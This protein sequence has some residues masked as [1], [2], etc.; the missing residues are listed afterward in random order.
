MT[1]LEKLKNRDF[2][3]VLDK[4][5]SMEESDTPTGQSRW[6]YA[7]ESAVAIARKICEFDPD[8]ITFIPFAGSFKVY[9]NTTEAALK[10]VFAEHSPMGGTVL[11]PVLK[12][13]FDSYKERKKSGKTKANGEMLLVVTD[14]QPQ[15]ASEVAK[16]IVQFG[17]SLDNADS[18]YG[19]S[20]IQVGKAADATAFLKKLDDDL[21]SQGAKHDIVDTKTMD[22][23]ESLGLTETLIA[24]LE[25]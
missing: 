5:G 6:D 21:T 13:V 4:S 10:Q 9:E 12:S 19:I 16:T 1:N 7:K 18:E 14:G 3:L 15:D 11:A 8:G 17:N 25:D 2:V 20:F 22:E 23:V 24:A